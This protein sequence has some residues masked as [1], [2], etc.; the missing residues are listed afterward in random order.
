MSSPASHLPRTLP[1]RWKPAL[2]LAC[3]DQKLMVT[4]VALLSVLPPLR[5]KLHFN[6]QRAFCK[7][8]RRMPFSQAPLAGFWGQRLRRGAGRG[9]LPAPHWGVSPGGG[10]LGMDEALLPS[11]GAPHSSPGGEILK[12]PGLAGSPTQGWAGRGSY[13]LAPVCSGALGIT[14]THTRCWVTACRVKKWVKKWRPGFG[15]GPWARRAIHRWCV[16]G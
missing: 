1:P 7:R 14:H 15:S 5:S 13:L 9:A 16:I 2:E 3:G 11:W 12:L 10:Q 6:G 8:R 4:P